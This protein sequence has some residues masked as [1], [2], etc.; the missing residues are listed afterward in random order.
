MSSQQS[1]QAHENATLPAHYDSPDA[2]R[3]NILYGWLSPI[4]CAT[5]YC[6]CCSNTTPTSS[7]TTPRTHARPYNRGVVGQVCETLRVEGGPSGAHVRYTKEEWRP[8]AEALRFTGQPRWYLE[9]IYVLSLRC[10]FTP[11][12]LHSLSTCNTIF[13][14]H[15]PLSPFW[16]R[17]LAAVL[18]D[19]RRS[20]TLLFYSLATRLAWNRIFRKILVVI[21]DP[22]LFEEPLAAS[23]YDG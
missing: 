22:S 2:P 6:H 10:A 12:L 15:T 7:V 9:F 20:V 17:P 13:P 8:L 18:P 3:P 11:P 23:A 1:A 19:A 14:I 4:F 16:S 21:V 5:P